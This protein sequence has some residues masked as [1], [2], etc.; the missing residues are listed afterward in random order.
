[1]TP[2]NTPNQQPLIY[3]IADA[4]G[5]FHLVAPVNH[6]HLTTEVSGLTEALAAKANAASV[7]TALAGKMDTKI[8]DSTPSNNADHL[9]SSKGV[10]DALANKHDLVGQTISLVINGQEIEIESA[11]VPNLLRALSDPDTTPTTDSNKLITSGGV[12]DAIDNKT[13]LSTGVLES[14]VGIENKHSGDYEYDQA[15]VI[16]RNRIVIGVGANAEDGSAIIDANN[17][18]NLQRAISNPDST[19]TANSDNLVTSGGVKAALN[20]KADTLAMNNALDGKAPLADTQVQVHT[21]EI[22][23]EIGTVGSIYVDNLFL[24]GNTQVTLLVENATGNTLDVDDAFFTSQQNDL[25]FMSDNAITPNIPAE[26][27]VACRILKRDTPSQSVGEH[28][29]LIIDGLLEF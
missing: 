18:A 16:G 29:Y 3:R 25:V 10:K 17:I 19:P 13:E 23:Q 7:E 1:M 28:Y 22:N 21:L 24:N 11:D 2:S 15:K 6:T 14:K 5:V 20:Q 12:K 9:V 4:A 8:I 27:I 26:S